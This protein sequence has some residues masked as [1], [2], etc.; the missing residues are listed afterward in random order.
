MK[1]PAAAWFEKSQLSPLAFPTEALALATP[2][3][4]IRKAFVERADPLLAQVA[5]QQVVDLAR[6]LNRL[7]V[8]AHQGKAPR[9]FVVALEGELAGEELVEHRPQ[10]EDIRAGIHIFATRRR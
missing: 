3:E 1:D 6:R 8:I 10:R 9:G 7:G 5:R 2:K 4:V